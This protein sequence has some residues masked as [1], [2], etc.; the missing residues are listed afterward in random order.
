MLRISAIED[1]NE[2][3]LVLEGK[4]IVPWTSEVRKACEKARQTLE[5]RELVV[6]LKNLTVISEQ[7]EDLLAALMSEGV[8]FRSR[9]VFAKHVLRRIARRA[10]A[11]FERDGISPHR[12]TS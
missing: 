6:D 7:G 11:Q 8:R 1:H 4:L 12:G 2:Q 5:G 3:R 9:G 10:Q